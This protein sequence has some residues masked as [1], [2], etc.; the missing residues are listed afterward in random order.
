MR[1]TYHET[2]AKRPFLLNFSVPDNRDLRFDSTGSNFN[3]PPNFGGVILEILNVF[4]WLKLS[5]FLN[6]DKK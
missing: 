1:E 2:F 6:L 3:P 5:P 4:L